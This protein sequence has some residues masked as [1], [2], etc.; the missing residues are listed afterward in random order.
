MI[1]Y[2]C[3]RYVFPPLK[4]WYKQ[5]SLWNLSLT[6]K[7]LSPQHPEINSS[8][9]KCWTHWSPVK[10]ISTGIREW[11]VAFSALNHYLDQCSYIKWILS[12]Q[13]QWNLDQN[14]TISYQENV[15]KMLSKEYQHR[16]QNVNSLRTT[17]PPCGHLDSFMVHGMYTLGQKLSDFVLHV[18]NF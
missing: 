9:Q 12:N 5:P 1:Y 10:H 15:F 2:P 8:R 3:S 14:K 4:F 18:S 6:T 16:P 13:L 11:H 7:Y 17:P